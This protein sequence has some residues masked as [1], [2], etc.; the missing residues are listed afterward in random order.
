MIHELEHTKY[1]LDHSAIVALTDKTGKI[2][3]VNDKF[4]E[5]SGYSREEL[6]GKTHRVINSQYHSA[7][8]M[9]NLWKTILSG[10]IWKGEIRNKT[11][12]GK[13]YW[14]DTTITPLLD[15]KGKPEQFI[16]IHYDI[17]KLKDLEKQKDEFIGIASHELKTPVTSLKGYAQVLRKRFIKD[18]NKVA[19]SYMDKMDS[20]INKLSFLIQDLLDVTKIETGKLQF[21]TEIIDMNHLVKEILETMQLTTEK[22]L[23]VTQGKIKHAVFGDRERIGQVMI[24]LISNA[25]K[26]SPKSDKIHVLLSSDTNTVKICIKDYGVGIPKEKQKHVFKRFYRVSGAKEDTFPG[27]GLGLYISA[28]IIKRHQGD[29]SVESTTGEGSTFCFI[30]PTYNSTV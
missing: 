17:T 25:I 8:F 14:V 30:L 29:M 26:Y 15:E 20:Q 6:I 28:E 18:G 10:N 27:L 24:N 19:V 3:Y 1:A 13:Y 12:N 21:H 16:A 7:D 2:K 22:H 23:I 9:K 5:I 4:V 11:K